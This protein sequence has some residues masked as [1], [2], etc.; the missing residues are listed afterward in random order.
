MRK[1]DEEADWSH[2]MNINDLKRGQELNGI[3]NSVAT[4]GVFVDVGAEKDGLV[5][6][7]RVSE[8][9]VGDINSLVQPGQSVKV[10]V[11]EV[12]PEGK[13]G[14]TMVKD[15]GAS[16]G[17]TVDIS[18]FASMKPDEWF[19]GT[20][21]SV[22]DFG[23]FVAV[24]P[25]G[26]GPTAQGLVHISQIRDGFVEHPAEEAEVGQQVKV[27]VKEVDTAKGKLK[28][29]MREAPMSGSRPSL[30]SQDVSC[31][32]STS[33][34][35][36]LAGVVHHTAPFGIFVYL[37][38]PGS[39]GTEPVTVQGMVHVTEIREGFVDDPAKEVKNGQEVSVR[40]IDVDTSTGRLKLSMKLPSEVE[41]ELSDLG[42]A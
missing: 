31:F 20:V 22:T 10:W 26:G 3:V 32:K 5:H 7:S 11:T 34:E 33:P 14:L 36:W 6:I 42:P 40:V 24:S 13:L 35:K 21:T 4:F 1:E 38:A 12:S 37:T 2:R 17:S 41:P 25:P 23:L 27:R 16:T 18:G 9:F 28:L 15:K 19:D 29:S 30:E 39:S 8:G